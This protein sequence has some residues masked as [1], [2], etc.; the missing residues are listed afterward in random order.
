MLWLLSLESG[1]RGGLRVWWGVVDRV[2][3][4]RA[5]VKSLL[6]N[7]WVYKRTN[8]GITTATTTAS[9]VGQVSGVR[10]RGEDQ[11]TL[12][13]SP[14]H[15]GLHC[16]HSINLNTAFCLCTHAA[17]AVTTATTANFA[18][19]DTVSCTRLTNLPESPYFKICKKK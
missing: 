1:F 13:K 18:R 8:T 12:N 11:R 9:V 5:S 4:Y 2:D 3:G 7:E 6:E 19:Y 14:W 16:L 17:R 10:C 15:L